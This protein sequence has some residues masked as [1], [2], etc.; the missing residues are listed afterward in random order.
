[1]AHAILH[2]HVIVHWLSH[3]FTCRPAVLGLH[4]NRPISLCRAPGPPSSRS[5][6]PRWRIFARPTDYLS[7]SFANPTAWTQAWG[8]VD[9]FPPSRLR[10]F[11][12]RPSFTWWRE[13]SSFQRCNSENRPGIQGISHGALQGP[14]KSAIYVHICSRYW[15]SHCTKIWFENKY[16][17][18]RSLAFSPWNEIFSVDKDEHTLLC[19]VQKQFF[20]QC[21]F[22]PK[23]YNSVLND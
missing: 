4:S 7:A 1:M 13:E 17:P 23:I 5:I 9:L 19:T 21:L 6:C 15:P 3:F 16:S 2:V 14:W 8:S 11:F 18:A 22:S 10:H 12:P 20:P